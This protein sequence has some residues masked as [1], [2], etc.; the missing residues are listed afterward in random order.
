[1]QRKPF[2][3]TAALVLFGLLLNTLGLVIAMTAL[4]LMS[5]GASE[6]FRLEW[7]ATAGLIALRKGTRRAN[8][9]DG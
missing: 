5:A 9:T 1:M 4:I 8:A 7:T 2:L 3:I 6:A